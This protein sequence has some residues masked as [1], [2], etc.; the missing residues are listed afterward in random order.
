MSGTFTL[1]KV[2]K[3]LETQ[4]T[5]W[6]EGNRLIIEGAAQINTA[7]HGLPEVRTLFMTVDKQVDIAFHLVF[8][9]P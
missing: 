3:P 4:V 1:N 7:D 8:D 9:L 5:A 6:R 2:A